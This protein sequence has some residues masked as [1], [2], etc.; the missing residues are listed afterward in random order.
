MVLII[1]APVE[2]CR[3]RR[4]PRPSEAER[5]RLVA[6]IVDVPRTRGICELYAADERSE[7][8]C[9]RRKLPGSD[10][11][12]VLFFRVI[13]PPYDSALRIPCQ[14]SRALRMSRSEPRPPGVVI[15]PMLAEEISE[16]PC[17]SG[18]REGL[19]EFAPIRMTMGSR[20]KQRYP[21]E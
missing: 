15:K 10:V 20:K 11:H 6:L 3:P 21:D 8:R 7:N 19:G 17:G 12:K 9:S 2:V 14:A 4:R 5:P 18:N 13:L 1:V 16:N